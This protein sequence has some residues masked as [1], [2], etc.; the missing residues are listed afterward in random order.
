MLYLRILCLLLPFFGTS[1]GAAG[2]FI[3]HVP[4]G[5]SASARLRRLFG[6]SAGIMTA[7]SFFSLLLPALSAAKDFGKAAFLPVAGGLL[8]GGAFPLFSERAER[9]LNETIDGDASRIRRMIAAVVLHNIPEGMAVGVMLSGISSDGGLIVPQEAFALSLGIALQNL[10]E[11]AIISLPLSSRGT[12]KKRA[13]ICGVLSGVVEPLSGL[14]AWLFV[15]SVAPLMPLFL[16]FAAGAM[17]FVTADE[18]IPGMTKDGTRSD[19][20]V[21]YMIGFALMMTLDLL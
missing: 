11:G 17:L 21:L 7:A 4:S 20:T 1:L 13:F 12:S 6:F 18:L 14:A 19:G 5:D 10:P 8:L 9:R 2:V 3:R 15:H 16:S